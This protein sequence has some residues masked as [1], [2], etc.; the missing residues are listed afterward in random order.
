MAKILI[1]DDEAEVRTMVRLGLTEHEV[2][3]AESGID[4]LLSALRNRPELILLD[5]NMPG[6]DGYEV[7]RRLRADPDLAT[8]PVIFSTFQ[9]SLA[10][11][12]EGFDAGADDYV[13]KP[14][15]LEELDMRVKAVLRRVQPQTEDVTLSVANI[16]LNLL[17]RE[18]SGPQGVT[19]LTPT[20]FTLL[21]YLMRHKGSL[22]PTSRLLEDVWEYP[23]GVGDP[24]LARTHIRNLREKLEVDS[25]NPTF[26]QTVGRQGYTIKD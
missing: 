1:I 15:D 23:P 3:E 4:G 2:L 20:E 10:D 25:S 16:T 17:S 13:T 14:F 9:G 26:I 18:V 12:L 8:T 24:A 7:C 19:V 6:V 21:E 5:V 22:I 11:K